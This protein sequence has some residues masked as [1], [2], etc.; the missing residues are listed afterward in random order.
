VGRR[1]YA[2]RLNRCRGGS[3]VR[4]EQLTKWTESYSYDSRDRLTKAC[5]NETCS[6]YYAYSYDAVGNRT[7]LETR[8]AETLYTYDL[9]DELVSA[10]E[11]KHA[12]HQE[13][14]HYAY[15]LNGN[16]TRAGSALYAY[17]L[18]NKLTRVKDEH[19]HDLVSYSYS[20]E[21]LMATRSSHSEST[22]YAWD[23]S[24]ELP[25]LAQETVSKGQGRSAVRDVRSYTY[26]SGPIG[27]V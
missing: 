10:S 25:E 3:R 8:K 1:R 26:G 27:I 7:S 14:T 18:E 21:G 15:D 19:G 11:E 12:H 23:T 16:Q 6:H 5:M 17:N 9:A 2:T 13:V 4:G 22:S 24:S 20:G